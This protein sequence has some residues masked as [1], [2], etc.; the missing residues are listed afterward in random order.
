MTWWKDLAQIIQ[1][2][3]TT[4]AFIVAGYW[5]YLLYVRKRLKY[6]RVSIEISIDDIPLTEGARIIHAGVKIIN[7]GDVIVT[8]NRAELRL[9]Q[10]EPIPGVIR[11]FAQANQDPVPSGE[12]EIEWPMIA[13][14]I[15]QFDEAD[16]EV[17]PGEDDSLHADFMIMNDI[18]VVQIYFFLSNAAKSKRN[19]GWTVTKIYKVNTIQE[20]GSMSNRKTTHKKLVTNQQKQQKQ[21]VQ[22]Q[23]QQQQ[24][25][26]EQPKK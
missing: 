2:V 8:S 20:E 24:K 12:K 21:Q 17:E 4:F 23:Q 11:G 10:V 26:K 19:L 18:T 16:F 6:P 7:K 14:R 22:Q 3:A 25:R 13:G 5:T 9:R 15:W 1:A